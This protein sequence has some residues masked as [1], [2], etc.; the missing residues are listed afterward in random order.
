MKIKIEY[1]DGAIQELDKCEYE[2]HDN[3]IRIKYNYDGDAYLY[4]DLVVPM[5]SIMTFEGFI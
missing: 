1:I 3:Y 5:H 4:T 2:I